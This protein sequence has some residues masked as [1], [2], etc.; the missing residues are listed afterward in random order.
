MR[1]IIGI[2]LAAAVLWCG[3]WFVGSS[4][5]QGQISEWFEQ[6]RSEDWQ[7]DYSDISVSGFPNR[8]DTTISDLVLA[9][10]ETG[11]A[12][13]A[14]FFQLLTL[15]Y[16]PNEIIAVWPL[17]QVIATPRER[18]DILAAKMQGSLRLGAATSLPLEEAIFVIDRA[19]H[20]HK[21]VAGRSREPPFR[22]AGD[23]GPREHLRL[24]ARNRKV[25]P[26]G[27]T[28]AGTRSGW[29]TTRRI[30]KASPRRA[31][32]IRHALGPFCHRGSPASAAIN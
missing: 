29:L 23:R 2:C 21:P 14:P 30:R 7:A 8:F 26:A 24:R 28:K 17:T 32:C 27:E 18:F 9:D 13:E 15:S 16:K 22:P 12:W 1:A 10:P 6:R 20:S 3:Y 5:L 4:T 25:E 19:P 31:S 11:V